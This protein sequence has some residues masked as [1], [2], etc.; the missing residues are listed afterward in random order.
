MSILSLR[1]LARVALVAVTSVAALGA[2]AVPATAGAKALALK[3]LA[4]AASRVDATVDSAVVPLTWTVTNPDAAAQDMYGSLHIQMAGPTPGSYVGQTYEV[5]FRFED[6]T[7]TKARWVSGTPRRSTY[8]YDFVVPRFAATSS[9]QWLVTRFEVH[10]ERGA[11]LTLDRAALAG[12]RGTVTARTVADTTPPSSYWAYLE[13]LSDARP[14]TYVKDREGYLRYYV[15]VQDWESGV[16][17]GSL[18]LTGP[19]GQTVTGRFEAFF[20]RADQRCGAYSG[21]DINSTSCSIEVRIPANAAS[22]EW[23]VTELALTDNVGNLAVVTDH[24]LESIIVTSNASLSASGFTVSPNP[25]NNWTVNV[26]ATLGMTVAGAQ[27]GVREILVDFDNHGCRQTST[28]PTVGADGTIGLPIL[29]YSRTARCTVVG[30]AIRDAAGGLALYGSRYEAPDP[31]LTIR[32]LTSTTPPTAT[33]VSVTPTTVARSQ[34][35]DTRPVVSMSVTAPVAPVNGYSMYLYAA[36]GTVVAQ[37]FGGTGAGP[38]GRLSLYGYLPYEI[39]AGTYT[40]GFTLNDASGLATT[41]GPGG[42]P[43]PGGP[44]TL[45]VTDE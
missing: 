31:G 24:G 44:L 14:Y 19:G 33:D 3:S 32:Q 15:A 10:D 2:T 25:V 23:R 43:M 1:L 11:A 41:Y 27:E 16:W 37:Q 18:Q 42:L 5:D 30:L 4:F 29:V 39:T 38:D 36:D 13:P 17:Q 45:T 22:G 26:N 21:G 40:Y 20:H 35:P 8:T 12:H 28:T 6:V 9:A 7:Y 34:A